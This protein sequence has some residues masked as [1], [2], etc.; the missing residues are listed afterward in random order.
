MYGLTQAVPPSSEPVTTSL[1]KSHLRLNTTAE[2]SLLSMYITSARETFENL[3]QRSCLTTTWRLHLDAFPRNVIRLPMAPLQSVTSV[4]YY[5]SNDNLVTWDAANYSVDTAREPGRIVPKMWFPDWRFFSVFPPLSYKR[6]PKIIVEF[7]AGWTTDTIPTVVKQG[8]LLLAAHYFENRAEG[9][10]TD[11]KE[12][13]HGFQHIVSQYSLTWC[14]NMNEPMGGDFGY[15][16][17]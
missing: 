2:D 9:Q 8:I 14:G 3:T 15:L 10:A 12:L 17:E 13:P 1:L 6:S 7:V 5:D 16:V 4:T 11:L